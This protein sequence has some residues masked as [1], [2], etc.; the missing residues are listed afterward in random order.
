MKGKEKVEQPVLEGEDVQN[1]VAKEVI[2][3]GNNVV[4]MGG[5][6]E[7]PIIIND[8]AQ[9]QIVSSF[10][11]SQPRANDH[12]ASSSKLDP[13]YHQP[14]WCPGGLTHSEEKVAVDACPREG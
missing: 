9:N 3:I 8:S 12:E 10:R 11:S 5:C 1:K 13:K 4:V 7:G 6:F 2:K 14:R